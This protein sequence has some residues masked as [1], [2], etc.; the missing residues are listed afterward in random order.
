[1]LGRLAKALKDYRK[2]KVLR[3][4]N[5]EVGE[6]EAEEFCKALGLNDT[7]TKLEIRALADALKSNC[8]ITHVNLYRN[9]IRGESAKALAH[10]LNSNRTVIRVDL[11]G[12]NIGDEGAKALAD[13]LN[14]NHTVI[15]VDL[16]FN[17]IGDEGAKALADALKSNCT[18][19]DINLEYNKIG[20]EGSKAR[21]SP[22][23]LCSLQFRPPLSC[24]RHS[25]TFAS[26][27]MLSM[28]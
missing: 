17:F 10:A 4:D 21:R 20:D 7:I 16:Q 2:L 8:T 14:S 11:S 12:N 19:T 1:E 5:T 26:S 27:T 9:D 18:V 24:K 25:K 13:A 15:C 28:S 6:A 22:Q 23:G 3:L